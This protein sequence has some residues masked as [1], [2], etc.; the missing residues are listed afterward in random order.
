MVDMALQEI[1]F[2]TRARDVQ[3]TPIQQ[4]RA[5]L[6]RYQCLHVLQVGTDEQRARIPGL[7]TRCRRWHQP[8]EAAVSGQNATVFIQQRDHDV[9]EFLQERRQADA[10]QRKN[11][12][13]H[14]DC[15]RKT[16]AAIA[17]PIPPRDDAEGRR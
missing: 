10:F 6:I 1:V 17:A 8:Q 9:V 15:F 4:Q 12:I 11:H 16:Q 3:H 2:S 13:V 7:V 5:P 14:D